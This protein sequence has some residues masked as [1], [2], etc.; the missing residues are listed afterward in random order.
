MKIVVSGTPGTGKTSVSLLLAERL[1]FEYIDGNV[2]ASNKGI[3]EKNKEGIKEIPVEK[4][5]DIIDNIDKDVVID[6]HIAQNCDV[7]FVFVLRCNPEELEKRLKERKWEKSKISENIKAEILD[8]CLIDAVEY[9][10]NVYEID[11]SNMDVKLVV[12][13]IHNILKG[14]EGYRKKY[15]PGTIDWTDKYFNYL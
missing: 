9:N 6:S 7:D 1:G 13:I 2:L 4:F 3:I 12:S 8:S 5:C 11:T 10:V 14:T 15:E